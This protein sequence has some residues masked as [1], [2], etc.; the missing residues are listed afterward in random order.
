MWTVVYIAR[1]RAQADMLK[2]ILLNEGM[3][4]DIRPAGVS[5]IIG[6]GLFELIVPESEAME[7]QEILCQ[8][9]AK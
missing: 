7:A 5:G 6:D 4:A 8:Y 3:L 9:S 1:N 2:N